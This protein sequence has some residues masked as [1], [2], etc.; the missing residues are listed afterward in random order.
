[1][2]FILHDLVSHINT[3]YVRRVR[4]LERDGRAPPR[5]A[6][7][8]DAPAVLPDDLRADRQPKA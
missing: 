5:R 1:M 6:R 2:Q 7:K 4:Q 8:P 3:Y